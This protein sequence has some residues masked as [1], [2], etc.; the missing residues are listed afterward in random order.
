MPKKRVD[1]F[2]Q[3]G[4]SNAYDLTATDTQSDTY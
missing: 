1:L 3:E 2:L 4:Y